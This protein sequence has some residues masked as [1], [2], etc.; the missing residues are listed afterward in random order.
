MRWIVMMVLFFSIPNIG[1]AQIGGE[2][3]VYLT[4]E[5]IDPVFNNGGI[6]EFYTY[7]NKEFDFSKV[8]KK[9]R[10]ITVFTIN[11]LGEIKNIKVTQFLDI[12][13]AAEIIRVL[14]KAPN[15]QPAKKNGKPISVEIKLPSDF[16]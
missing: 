5:R 16:K 13:S 3:E 15:W 1:L 10:M 12:E 14:K 11:E 4:M 6:K 7:I 9:G 8:S 2:G